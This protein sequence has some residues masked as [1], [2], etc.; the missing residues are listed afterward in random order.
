MKVPVL[1]ADQVGRALI[2]AAGSMD[3]DPTFA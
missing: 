2:W 1:K 3:S